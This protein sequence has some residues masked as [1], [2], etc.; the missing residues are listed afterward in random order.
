MRACVRLCVCACVCVCHLLRQSPFL[1]SVD[2]RL[3]VRSFLI[4][5][6]FVLTVHRLSL[7]KT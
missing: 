3:L 4:L 1:L 7:S 6:H 5:L 2:V